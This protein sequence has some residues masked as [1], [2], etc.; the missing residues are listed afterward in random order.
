MMEQEE[1][2]KIKI[3]DEKKESINRYEASDVNK[4][5]FRVIILDPPVRRTLWRYFIINL[6]TLSLLLHRNNVEH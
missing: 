1:M 6:I 2:K 3:I 5:I 4:S